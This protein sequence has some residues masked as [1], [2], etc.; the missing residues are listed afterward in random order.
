MITFENILHVRD[1]NGNFIPVLGAGGNA[2]SVALDA[3]LTESGKAADAKATGDALSVQDERIAALEQGGTGSG[4]GA[5]GE[6]GVSPTV[7]VT[8]IDGGHR[9]TI[10]DI[11]GTQSFDVMDGAD[12]AGG[13]GGGE[14]TTFEY[15]V[16]AEGVI[17]N[18]TAAGTYIDTGLTIADLKQWKIFGYLAVASVSG[19]YRPMVHYN[20]QPF[21]NLNGLRPMGVYEWLDV[22]NG[23]LIPVFVSGADGYWTTTDDPIGITE[24][25]GRGTT[26]MWGSLI[27][28]VTSD[29]SESI[30]MQNHGLTTCEVQWKIFGYV[31]YGE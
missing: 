26:R 14:T 8:E 21:Y 13:S 17:P 30:Y 24:N 29:D 18:E 5:D 28:H 27:T 1:G 6:D 7:T 23:Y 3:T 20:K 4:T 31:K 10:T 12:G 22:Q 11:N 15:T 19:Y 9:V 25:S 16:L 2:G